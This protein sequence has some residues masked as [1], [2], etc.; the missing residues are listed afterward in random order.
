MGVPVRYL[1]VW[2]LVI[3]VLTLWG[4]VRPAFLAPSPAAG[5]FT[6]PNN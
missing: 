5:A 6:L 4:V 2:L 1:R 3:G